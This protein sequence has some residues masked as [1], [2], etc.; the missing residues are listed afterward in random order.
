MSSWARGSR[1]GQ[2]VGPDGRFELLGEL[3]EGGSAVVYRAMDRALGRAVALKALPDSV[4]N[5]PA[6]QYYLRREFR[7]R[8]DLNHAN[9]VTFHELVVDEALT[10]FTM[11]LV[12]GADLLSFV[13]E[14]HSGPEALRRAPPWARAAWGAREIVAGLLA[15]HGAGLVHR[16]LKPANVRMS[17]EGRL[18]ILDFGLALPITNRDAR[19]SEVDLTAGTPRFMAPD[20]AMSDQP[21]PPADF[22]SLGV[23]LCDALE[24]ELAER[25]LGGLFFTTVR[26]TADRCTLPSYVPE[27]LRDLVQRLLDPSPEARADARAVLS[28]VDRALTELTPS[29]VGPGPSLVPLATRAANLWQIDV[30]FEGRRAELRALYG[31]LERAA[32]GASPTVV[33]CTGASGHG[34]TEL[35]GHFLAGL[36]NTATV[37]CLRGRCHPQETVPFK[38]LDALMDGMARFLG[39]LP[40]EELPDPVPEALLK[41]FPVLGVALPTQ[42]DPKGPV[43]PRELRRQGALALRAFLERLATRWKLILWVDDLQWGDEDSLAL[44]RAV[45]CEGP[46]LPSLWL[47]SWRLED[48]ARAQLPSA[49]R[50]H[51]GA[52]ALDVTELPVGPMSAADLGRIARRMLL[53]SPS[54]DQLAQQLAESAGGSPF[55]LTMWSRYVQNLTPGGLS[56]DD[57]P[58]ALGEL[59]AASLEALPE[60]AEEL[61]R[62]VSVAGVPVPRSV[63][64]RAHGRG[65]G[66][67]IVVAALGQGFVRETRAGE[68]VL[69]APY[70]DRLR[71]LVLEAMSPAVRKARHRAL[72]DALEAHPE[73]DPRLLLEQLQ[74]ADEGRRAARYALQ[75]AERAEAALAFHQAVRMYR[76]ALELEPVAG[77]TLPKARWQLEESLAQALLNVGEGSEAADH[78]LRAAT[79]LEALARSSAGALPHSAREA[80]HL[81]RAAATHLLHN[82]RMGEGVTLMRGVLRDVGVELPEEDGAA[83]R[84]ALLGRMRFLARSIRATHAPLPP[85]EHDRMEACWSACSGFGLLRPLLA[86]AVS[87]ANLQRTLTYGDPSQLCRAL[88]FEASFEAS[89]GG[90]FLRWHAHRLLDHAF[91]FAERS[92]A[93]Y[94]RAWTLF[95]AG[96]IAF[97]EVR[98]RSARALCDEAVELFR[99]RCKGA[100]WEV[101][102]AEAF[103]LTAR[104]YEGD[105]RAVRQRQREAI[106]S[107]EARGDRFGATHLR[108]GT[109][110]L[111]L[112]AAG[113]AARAVTELDDAIAPW[114]TQSFLTQHY[115]HLLAVVQALLAQARVSEARRRVEEAWPRIESAG[116]LRMEFARGELLHLRGRVAVAEALESRSPRAQWAE[117]E[118]CVAGIDGTALPWSGPLAATLRAALRWQRGDRS[119][120]VKTLVGAV[121]AYRTAEMHLHAETLEAQ[122]AELAPSAE[123]RGRGQVARAWLGEHGVEAPGALARALLPG[124]PSLK[125]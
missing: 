81:R 13:R 27:L 7:S 18:V 56:D 52:A 108:L 115:L 55:L 76:T 45:L 68:E 33:L 117:V 118:R 29:V 11:D 14:G 62:L 67:R 58:K 37:L 73:A 88:G 124:F 43:D 87:V 42:A 38:A 89:L 105:L 60:G 94:D 74:A 75:A 48:D 25:S 85:G 6:Q 125:G 20:I 109:P 90:S 119:G 54:R 103:A 102:L 15:L 1:V 46:P 107:A 71:E 50:A 123:A 112:V 23:L 2:R 26:S 100:F 61:L 49:L 77:A 28:T 106:A 70:H 83:L 95:S 120:A 113:E 84:G 30:P 31:A 21:G 86:D 57:L 39:N 36:G 59:L 19:H 9:L 82:G 3:G 96:I 5:D 34:K 32:R 98:W 92:G 64:L 91:A 99:G 12:D 122:V 66:A 4:S 40:P 110:S 93:P 104:A 80:L 114:P 51:L 65:E 111:H 8:A 101:V 63:V 79:L 97:V 16:D 47:F 53:P 41:L 17:A 121:G 35:L 69:L 116:W 24:G 78:F 72:A 22:Y 10:F 44:L